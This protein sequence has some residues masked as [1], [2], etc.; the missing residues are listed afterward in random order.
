[1]LD[2]R[3][4][5]VTGAGRGLG[6]EHAL[7]LAGL[8]ASVVVNDLGGAT[9]GSGADVSAAQQ[10][11][12]E[13]TA[14]GG[15]AVASGASVTSADGAREIVEAALATFG[16][17]HAVVNN[18]GI[19][20]DRML[21][22]MSE[23]DFD[24]VYAVHARGSFNMTQQAAIVWRER[25]K[26]GANAPRAIVNTTSASGLHG[27][28]GQTNYAAAKAAIATMTLTH[29]A[30][31]QRYGVKVN[32]IA[33]LARTRLTLQTPGMEEAIADAVFDPGNAAPL[34]ACLVAENCRFNG[35]V[36]SVY[37]G[38]VGIYQGW[39]IADEVTSTGGWSVE[40]MVAALDQLPD[41]VAT[42]TQTDAVRRRAA[43]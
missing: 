35:Q 31:L 16:D 2:R 10:V 36:F 5:V 19:L 23:A 26:A 11:V 43:S 15:S 41:S 6:R 8:G 12:D 9:D 33:P 27:M 32:C 7:L 38:G 34:V 24:E 21:V 40:S 17:L 1:M 37:G 29:A 22:S 18:A 28:V 14:A 3:V 4:I 30:E 39:S 25:S 42:V 20:R 13:I